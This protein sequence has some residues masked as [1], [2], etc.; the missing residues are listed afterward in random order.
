MSNWKLPVAA[1]LSISTGACA[2]LPFSRSP[3]PVVI[4]APPVIPP[5]EC[6]AEP[7]ARS[8]FQPPTLSPPITTGPALAIATSRAERAE[9]VAMAA[10]DH[11]DT[12]RARDADVDET[13]RRCAAF[14]RS[15]AER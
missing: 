6:Q 11:I 3:Q 1:V 10:L 7:P 12:D 13:M 4:Q 14:N 9:A 2:T 15:V 5:A 8:T